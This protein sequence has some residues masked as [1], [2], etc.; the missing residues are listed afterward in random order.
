MLPVLK[1]NDALVRQ[2][3]P[4]LQNTQIE[5]S[6]ETAFCIQLE[7]LQALSALIFIMLTGRSSVEKQGYFPQRVICRI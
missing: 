7:C 4:H 6:F 3:K 2:I 5:F 1:L